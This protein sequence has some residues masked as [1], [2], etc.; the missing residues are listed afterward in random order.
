MPKAIPITLNGTTYKSLREASLELGWDATYLA[1]MRR[2]ERLDRMG[3]NTLDPKQARVIQL[4]LIAPSLSPWEISFASGV[5][6]NHTRNSLRLAGLTVARH[7][8]LHGVDRENM[9]WL[10]NEAIRLECSTQEVLNAVVTDARLEEE[11]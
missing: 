1:K 11:E 7:F 3:Q 8:T 10:I 2:L 6:L 9:R 4:G 5:S